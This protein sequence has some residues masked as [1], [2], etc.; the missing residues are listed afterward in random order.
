MTHDDIL[1]AARER[2]AEIDKQT[3]AMAEER[4]KLQA[5]LDASPVRPVAA[6]VTGAETTDVPKLDTCPTCHQQR[7]TI[8]TYRMCS[9]MAQTSARP[10]PFY[11]DD[12]APLTSVTID[13]AAGG[14]IV[15]GEQRPGSGIVFRS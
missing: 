9:C 12:L 6:W 11:R 3:A 5:M 8:G 15:G 1:K 4:G 13:N 2:I 7:W 10:F 14:F